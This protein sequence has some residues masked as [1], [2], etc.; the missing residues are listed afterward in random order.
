MVREEQASLLVWNV[1]DVLDLFPSFDTR[2]W[3][4]WGRV[5]HFFRDG[6][7]VDVLIL[8]MRSTHLREVVFFHLRYWWL[9]W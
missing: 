2:Q 8:R 9:R 7:H 3:P 4:R 6:P 5:F 1:S